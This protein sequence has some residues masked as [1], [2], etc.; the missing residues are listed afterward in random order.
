M[1]DKIS[2][3][4]EQSFLPDPA[5]RTRRRKRR[6]AIDRLAGYGMAVGGVS[7]IIAILLIFFYLLYEVA[8]LLKSAEAT[9]VARYQAPGADDV[10]LAYL[11]DEQVEMAARYTMSGQVVFFHP[12]NGTTHSQTHLPLPADVRIVSYARGTPHSNVLAFGLNDGKVLVVRQRFAVSYPDNRRVITP[13]LEYPLGEAPLPLFEDGMPVRLLAVQAAGEE[14]GALLAGW[15]GGAQVSL[16]RFS[17]EESFLEEESTL[18]QEQR[19]LPTQ[20]DEPSFMLLDQEMRTLYLATG[21]G[22]LESYDVAEPEQATLRQQVTLLNQ[23]QKLTALNF[24]SGE[25]SLVAGDSDGGLTQWFPVRDARGTPML[26]RIRA[27]E[28]LHGP[29]TGLIAEEQRK[30]F[31]AVDE[32]GTLGVF[33]ATAQQTLLT[34]PLG[35]SPTGRLGLAPRANAVLAEERSG[36]LHFLRLANAHPEA[37]WSALWGKVWYES[38]P[39]PDYVWQSSSAS[40]DFEPKFSLVP[41]SYGTLKAA[42]YAL[43]VSMPLAILGAVYTAYFMAPALRQVV[44]PAVEIMGALPSVILGFLAGLWLAPA[45]EKNLSGVFCMLLVLP[46]G[47]VAFAWAW[48][49]LP[50]RWQSF[51]PDG[52]QPLLMVPVVLVLTW[53]SLALNHPVEEALFGGDIR[54]WLVNEMH[55]GYDQ[56]NAI[57]VGLAMGFAVIPTIF[58]IAE[59][60]V[61]GVPKHLTLGSLAL[62]A[63]PWQTMT[64]VVLLTASPGIF[65]AVMIGMGRAVGETMIVLMATGNTPTTDFSPF[66]GMRT[67]AANIAVEMPESA[68][69]S[70]HYRVLILA[71][72]V[73]FGFT[74]IFNTIAEVVRHR[75]RL[76]YSSL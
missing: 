26:T 31:L 56:R 72:L 8:P 2:P 75:L 44:K 50:K 62:G 51:V 3:R 24:L 76:R 7:V 43:L 21:D 45:L 19:V 70:T 17:K 49:K 41:L 47:C 61:F 53:L 66:Q 67:L 22:Q 33:H 36:Q 74:F 13:Q 4:P 28:G 18:K 38:Y 46:A 54:N 32:G 65:S 58:S 40:N 1:T 68:L 55:V 12:E 6:M 52:W 27:F 25:I 10:T 23:G 71:A 57:V 29:V 30:G 9:P 15:S 20:M 5:S 73:L 14:G 48:H 34:R 59:D 39:A 11:L 64:R 37:S 16:V 60:A 63:T 42:L 35:T 69:G